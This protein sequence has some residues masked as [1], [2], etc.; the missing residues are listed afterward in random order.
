MKRLS[1]KD[2]VKVLDFISSEFPS[3]FVTAK[4]V[5]KKAAPKNSP[6]HKYFDWDDTSAAYR[7]RLWQARELIACLVVEIDGV[8]TRKFVT[9]VAI[10]LDSGEESKAYVDI[11]VARQDPD[12]WK[13]VLTQALKDATSWRARYEHLKELKNIVREIKK[14]EK[15]LGSKK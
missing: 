11:E 10:H 12:I 8:E 5:L 13:Q 2:K 7:Y 6:I 3:G 9:P 4:E 1:G 15:K 14:A